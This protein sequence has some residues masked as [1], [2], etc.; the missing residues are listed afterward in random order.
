MLKPIDGAPASDAPRLAASMM[1]GPPPVAITL[2]RGAPVAAKAPPRRETMR[3]KARAASYIRD[4][5]AARFAARLSAGVFAA[6][7]SAAARSGEG[8][9]ADPNTTTVDRTP[10]SRSAYS[11]FA[12]SMPKRKG[13]ISSRN[14]KA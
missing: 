8:M 9:R 2:S 1:P 4:C 12:Y 13:R 5:S 14:R 11:A 3:A 7:A 6:A 10:Q